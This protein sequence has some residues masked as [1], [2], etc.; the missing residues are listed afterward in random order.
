MLFYREDKLLR[1]DFGLVWARVEEFVKFAAPE[2]QEPRAVTIWDEREP[3]NRQ[4]TRAFA[5]EDRSKQ[6]EVN[7][8]YARARL[9]HQHPGFRVYLR[10]QPQ[11]GPS[12]F[13]PSAFPVNHQLSLVQQIRPNFWLFLYL[14]TSYER[15][16]D[17]AFRQF[18]D[19][20]E[21]TLRL[22]LLPKNWRYISIAKS[23][24]PKFRKVEWL[25]GA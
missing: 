17:P 24:N 11:F 18:L 15:H 22:R 6:P 7:E 25:A 10:W 21:S 13:D 16:D 9:A 8:L 4:E 20:A 23:G 3:A 5:T 14:V 19:Q 2:S 1:S 12:G